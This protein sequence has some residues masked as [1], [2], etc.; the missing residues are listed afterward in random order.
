MVSC[1][2]GCFKLTSCRGERILSGKS[3]FHKGIDL[4][5][6][7]DTAVYSIC[8]GIID[9][10]P[11][12]KDGFGYYVRQ[13]T[14]D[15][16]RIYYAHLKKGSIA[17][18]AGQKIKKGERLGEMGSTGNSTGAH[19]HLE[20]RPA[21]SGSESEDICKFTGIPNAIGRYFYAEKKSR[22]FSDVTEDYWAYEEIEYLADKGIIMGYGDG[23]FKPDTPMTRAE[24][25]KLLYRFGTVFGFGNSN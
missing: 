25:A 23:L 6:E 7:D 2:K 13:K 18:T 22:K 11:Y 1:F 4:V 24:V 21:G 14:E 17:V 19:T 12:E 8:D 20:I 9:A 3:E 16:R 10:T 5:G 15:G